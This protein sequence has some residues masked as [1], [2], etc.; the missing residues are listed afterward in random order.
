[1]N[2]SCWACSVIAIS[3]SM[4]YFDCDKTICGWASCSSSSSKLVWWQGCP[5]ESVLCQF[6]VIRTWPWRGLGGLPCFL[7]YPSISKGPVPSCFHSTPPPRSEDS[8]KLIALLI[9][10]NNVSVWCISG[11]CHNLNLPQF[12]L[13]NSCNANYS[14]DLLLFHNPQNMPFFFPSKHLG[15]DL[16]FVLQLQSGHCYGWL[17]T[18]L[19]PHWTRP[20]LRFSRKQSRQWC[21]PS[22]MSRR[23]LHVVF[24][25]TCLMLFRRSMRDGLWR[26]PFIS[27]GKPLY[28]RQDIIPHAYQFL[29]ATPWSS[30]GLA[31]L[32]P[33]IQEELVQN[34]GVLPSKILQGAVNV[35]KVHV[36]CI[37]PP[38]GYHF[39]STTHF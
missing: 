33:T 19:N 15:P 35:R 21:H 38:L 22:F 34:L 1:M 16:V 26:E 24:K 11:R 30:H 13:A 25:F 18:I 4:A 31:E 14:E 36:I 10:D 6:V 12:V 28:Y 3:M 39:C 23:S 29:M 37:I 17:N 9:N 32:F 2:A 20:P 27:V 8:T 5:I 7:L